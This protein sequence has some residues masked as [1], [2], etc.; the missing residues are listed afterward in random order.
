[1]DIRAGSW[2]CLKC[3]HFS[4]QIK[5]RELLEVAVT[6][7]ISNTDETQIIRGSL[8]TTI[9]N[10]Y[11]KNRFVYFDRQNRQNYQRPLFF[12][13]SALLAAQARHAPFPEFFFQIFPDRTRVISNWVNYDSH[14]SS[15]Q[16]QLTGYHSQFIEW[17]ILLSGDQTAN[18][19][20][21]V[22][23]RELIA[24]FGT[25]VIVTHTFIY[26]NQIRQNWYPQLSS[27]RASKTILNTTNQS[28][29]S[30]CTYSHVWIVLLMRISPRTYK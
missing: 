10:A 6:T 19:L 11:R 17:H 2:S 16:P 22:A 13:T 26:R 27:F 29:V 7:P 9:H 18:S 3:V 5:I 21:S 1:M 4:L 15:P 28:T 8:K 30:H 20:L 25:S 23:R 24:Q 14:E 12:Y